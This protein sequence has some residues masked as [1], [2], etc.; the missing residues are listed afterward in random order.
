MPGHTFFE[1]LITLAIIAFAAMMMP[2]AMS[3]L[4]PE[5]QTQKITEDLASELRLARSRA[6][7]TGEAVALDVDIDGRRLRLQGAAHGEADWIAVPRGVIVTVGDRNPAQT[8]EHR[9]V[10]YPDGSAS[11]LNVRF[12]GK[13][14]TW[15]VTTSLNGKTTAAKE[16]N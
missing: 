4:R 10:F 14:S 9:V 8:G 13:R 15:H 2:M 12:A 3:A 11:G 7:T 6:A 5:L 1:L 16:P